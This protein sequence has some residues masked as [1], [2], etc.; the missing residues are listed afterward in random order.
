MSGYLFAA[1]CVVLGFLSYGAGRATLS[2]WRTTAVAVVA[3]GVLAVRLVTQLA[4]AAGATRPPAIA[5]YVSACLV[6][7]LLPL[8]AGRYVARQRA[9]RDQER[10]RIARDMHDSLGRALSLAAVQA[11]ALEVSDLPGPQR[12]AAA[13]LGA[14]I[15]A[16]VTELHEVVAVLRGP[17]RGMASAAELIEGFRAVGADLSVRSHGTPLP[18]SRQADE[19]AYRVH[20]EGLTNAMRHAPGQPV[21]VT[22]SWQAGSLTLTVVNPAG[23]H[24]YAPGAGLDGLNERLREAGGTLGHNLTDTTPGHGQAGG[25]FRLQA[26]LPLGRR[27]RLRSGLANHRLGL[28]FATGFVLLV[29]VPATV[30]LGVH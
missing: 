18:L 16:G 23:R 22:I 9:A 15:R 10:L 12:E 13:R 29:I 3:C 24:P 1:A 19:A 26:S 25:R 28:G 7:V 4:A 11:A 2:P 8:L 5:G 6:F 27:A 20:E 17:A 21:N 14:A 30:L